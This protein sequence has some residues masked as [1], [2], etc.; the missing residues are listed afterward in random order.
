M[1][2]YIDSI[3]KEF[4]SPSFP[5]FTLRDVRVLLNGSRISPRYLKVLVNGLIKRREILRIAS[6]VYTFHDELTVV[7]FAYRPFYYGMEDALSYSNLW[8][9]L[10]N[11]VVMTANVVR[12]G[13]RKFDGAN[14]VVK[15]I[16]PR[17]FFGFNFI[18]HY[19]VWM[20]VSDPEKT[21]IDMVYFRHHIDDG[22]RAALRKS[23]DRAKLSGY[24]D[25]YPHWVKAEVERAVGIRLTGR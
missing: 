17:F 23:L 3:R 8:N 9:Q 1:T 2:K 7:G 25:T 15:R 14:Y 21:L 24:L 22:V 6:G 5:V 16:A 12:E 20:P 13:I 11:P 4:N 18:R 10:A 19:E